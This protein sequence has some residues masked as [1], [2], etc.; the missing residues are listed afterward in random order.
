MEQKT[1]IE[2]E[3]GTHKSAASLIRA[4]VSYEKKSVSNATSWRDCRLTMEGDPLIP[5]ASS[6]LVAA[7]ALLV[8]S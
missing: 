7:S 1:Q 8:T 5:V 3:R 6:S 4:V 2:E